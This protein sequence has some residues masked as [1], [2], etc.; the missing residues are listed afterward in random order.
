MIIRTE[1]DLT[2]GIEAIGRI[3]P[4]MKRAYKIVGRPPLRRR[5]GGFEG[6]AR[7]VVGQQLSV[8]S[9]AA[10]W[11]RVEA[12]FTPFKSADL[13]KCA[14]DDLRGAGLSA[15]KIRTLRAIAEA[16]QAG[17]IK[18]NRLSRMSEEDLR[19][20]LI[21]LHGIGPWTADIYMMFCLGRADSWAPGDLALQIGAQNLLKLE[22]RPSIKQMDE[23]AMR[24]RP[25]RSVAARLLWSY[26]AHDKQ[27]AS[28]AK[29]GA[30]PGRRKAPR[31]A[32]PV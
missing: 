12:L 18:F 9:A 14:E 17:E 25:W 3:C 11:G 1:K 2:Q 10:I 29:S 27:Q 15:G 21:A 8:A 22:E 4:D 32:Q 31:Q 30:K 6:L 26:Y 28:V 19:A 5:K 16:E 23:I 24:W 7:I 20:A 13:L